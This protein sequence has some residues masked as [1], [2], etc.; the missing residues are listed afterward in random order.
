MMQYPSGGDALGYRNY[1]RLYFRAF[2]PLSDFGT[3]RTYGYPFFLYLVSFF[4]GPGSD[5]ALIIGAAITQYFLFLAATLWLVCEAKRLSVHAALAVALGLMI[6]PLVL[7]L[8]TDTLSESLSIIFVVAICASLLR[9]S[10]TLTW[11]NV[12]LYLAIASGL[13]IYATIVRPANVVIL[14][15]TILTIFAFLCLHQNLRGKRFR[16]TVLYAVLLS[17]GGVVILGPQVLYNFQH[18][19]RVTFLPVCRLGDMQASF[20]VALI[21]Y[22]TTMLNGIAAGRYYINPWLHGPLPTQNAWFWYLENPRSGLMTIIAHVFNAFDVR[23]LFT[24]ITTLDAW[25]AVALHLASWILNLLGSVQIILIVISATAFAVRTREMPPGTPVFV[26][27]TLL[28][29]GVVTLLAVSA[30]EVRFNAV[31]LTVLAVAGCFWLVRFWSHRTSLQIVLLGSAVLAACYFVQVSVRME[32]Y[33]SDSVPAD[34]LSFN[35]KDN[36]CFGDRQPPR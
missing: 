12:V 10:R 18:W 2:G 15:A 23:Y 31:P 21:K 8:V 24:Y 19:E 14:V 28:T 34:M 22:E 20:G 3:V 7:A 17:L 32:K 1:A 29:C 25:Y 6:N 30:V 11:L 26:F 16:S 36:Q 35:M 5:S 9:A 27:L 33:I 4:T 13:S